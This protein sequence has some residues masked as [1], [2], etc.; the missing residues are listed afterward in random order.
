M[1][2]QALPKDITAEHIRWAA[3]H[4]W[5][6]SWEYLNELSTDRAI[7]VKENGKLH[8]WPFVNYAELRAWA[9]Y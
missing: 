3:E 6:V 8:P 7:W 1:N 2:Y 4:D 5:F 9:G